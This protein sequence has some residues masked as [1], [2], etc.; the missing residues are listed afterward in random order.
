MQKDRAE[1]HDLKSRLCLFFSPPLFPP[2]KRR[3]KKRKI[4]RKNSDFKLCVS[5]R[6][7]IKV[8]T[9]FGT[10]RKWF[11]PVELLFLLLFLPHFFK[12]GKIK[13]DRITSLSYRCT[14]KV[15]YQA[16]NS[17]ISTIAIGI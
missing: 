6:S 1:R 8:M 16:K 14:L 9:I 15:K 17:R 3:E 7:Y 13:G 4:N 10:Q 12:G 2:K 11:K 5:D